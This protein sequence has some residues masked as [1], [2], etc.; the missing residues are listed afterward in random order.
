[1]DAESA[2]AGRRRK[3]AGAADW[4]ER[5]FAIAGGAL[6]G[7]KFGQEAGHFL[8]IRDVACGDLCKVCVGDARQRDLEDVDL[9]A[10]GQRQQKLQRSFKY[11]RFHVEARAS[12]WRFQQA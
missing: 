10:L 12:D 3:S 11:R 5:R 7:E 2:A 4:F 9:F 6:V 8:R 1:M